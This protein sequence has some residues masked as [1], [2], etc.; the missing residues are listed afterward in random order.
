M[1]KQWTTIYFIQLK[2][3]HIQNIEATIVC[4]IHTKVASKF[5]YVIVSCLFKTAEVSSATPFIMPIW[6][7]FEKRMEDSD[8]HKGFASR[9]KPNWIVEVVNERRFYLQTLL[10]WM[11][12]TIFNVFGNIKKKG[13]ARIFKA[14]GRSPKERTRL[15][16]WLSTGI[17]CYYGRWNAIPWIAINT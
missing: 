2:L 16:I 17:K 5:F 12:F 8:R 14:R 11:E 4:H 6:S 13:F 15:K 9:N 3:Q 10:I 1:L 7:S